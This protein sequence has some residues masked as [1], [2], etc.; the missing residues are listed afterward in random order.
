MR[1]KNGPKFPLSSIIFSVLLPL[2]FPSLSLSKRSRRELFLFISISL[3]QNFLSL[4]TIFPFVRI[5]RKILI[6]HRE[7]VTKRSQRPVEKN[8]LSKTREK[9]ETELQPEA[10]R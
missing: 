1:K 3:F 9:E 5:K 7:N 8:D 4:S 6:V 10:L 2:L